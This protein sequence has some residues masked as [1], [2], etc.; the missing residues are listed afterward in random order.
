MA[1]SERANPK[2]QKEVQ[3]EGTSG[4]TGGNSYGCAPLDEGADPPSLDPPET[5]P[6]KCDCPGSATTSEPP[7]FNQLITDQKSIAEAGVRAAQTQAEL[8]AMLDDATKAKGT[9]TR[10]KYDEFTKRWDKQDKD[11]VGAIQVVTCNIPCWWCVIE[12][13]ICP[14]LYK[15]RYLQTYLN[16]FGE[17]AMSDVHSLRDLQYWHQRRLEARQDRFK[18]I[19]AVFEAWKDPT[20]SIDAALQANQRIIDNIRATEPVDALKQVFFE[21]IPRHLAIAPRPLATEIKEKYRKLCFGCDEP[22]PDNCCGPDTGMP[23]VQQ[24][25]IGGPQAYIVDPDRYFD[26]LCCIATQRYEPARAQAEQAQAKLDALNGKIASLQAEL[27]KRIT[28]PLADYRG[29]ISAPID[30]DKYTKKDGGDDGCGCDDDED[31]SDEQ[32]V[33]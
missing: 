13:H 20:K 21:L 19:K 29:G 27:V 16:G 15:I 18:A 11:I 31:G 30:C 32:V 28:D 9:Y 12:C 23:T 25:L 24:M 14:L 26:L 1:N 8:Q 6:S 7:C 33:S 10:D 17:D 22:A 3:A 4:E 5:P 2:Q